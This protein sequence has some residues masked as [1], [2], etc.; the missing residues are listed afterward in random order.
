MKR[1]ALKDQNPGMFITY[2][3][4]HQREY[5]NA[6]AS[7]EVIHTSVG[8]RDT[9]KNIEPNTSVREG[10]SR[11]DY[12]F[13]RPSEAVPQLQKEV[14]GY[15]MEAYR[16][17]GVVRNVIDLMGD[18]GSQ[19]ITI[20]HPSPRIQEFYRKWF[21]KVRGVERSER[22][23]NLLYRCANVI[24]KRKM[25]KV[26]TGNKR[27]SSLSKLK[28][29]VSKIDKLSTEKGNIPIEYV[30]LNPLS[31]EIVGE[32]LSQFIGKN[33]YALK[34]PLLLSNTINYPKTLAEKQLVQQLPEDIRN[35][36]KSATRLL[37]LDQDKIRALF[38]K[39]DDWQLWADPMIR[40]ILDDLLLL[41][42]MKLADLA[43]LDGVI[44]QIRVW[45]LGHINDSHPEASLFPTATAINKL[46]NIL[47]SNTGGGVFD[48]IWGP[49]L[50][51]EDFS[52]TAHQFLGMSKYEPTLNSI[53]EGLGVPPTLTGSSSKGGMTNNSISLK[54]LIQRL[55]YGRGILVD[56]WVQEIELVRQAMGFK[57]PA[58][59]SFDRMILNDEASEKALLIQL[60][61]RN[62]ISVESLQKRMGE[63][64]ELEVLRMKRESERQKNGG[65]APK[66][67]PFQPDKIYELIKASLVKG[68]ITPKEAG[69]ELDES[70][71]KPPFMLQL[72]KSREQPQDKKP[73]GQPQQG[74]PKNAKDKQKRDQRTPKALGE[75][76]D[77][78]AWFLT[79]LTWAK[80][81]QKEL[82][83]IIN[84]AILS[85]VGKQNLRQLTDSETEYVENLKFIVLASCDP[86]SPIKDDLVY[87][88][89]EN[90]IQ[91]PTEFS[92]LYK[93]LRQSTAEK[94]NKQL[95]FDENRHIQAVTYAL[96]KG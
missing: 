45:K 21:D 5:A 79:R 15:C 71:D 47:L 23:L 52:T 10:F 54:T 24:V 20:N 31:L 73:T 30:F 2:N 53:Y 74:R 8:G 3:Q 61:D 7:I 90:N 64:P 48:L 26:S 29:D 4:E 11:S 65:M 67:G 51:F 94:L 17:I 57:Q 60:A 96:L 16:K 93:Q 35:A 36:A 13:F 59:I 80:Q 44:S 12:E 78:T 6:I 72:E 50:T 83:D 75:N 85:V 89:I 27:F 77:D 49:D 38:Y 88:S 62:L 46:H 58:T 19:G 34:L 1:P 9:W 41:E 56:F 63:L 82:A 40:A 22:F 69:L 91:L 33:A 39:K 92:T 76:V 86:F 68:L 37:L 32:S 18:F 66:V 14:I 70:F 42:K 95:S 55:E 25:A 87:K 84:P 81:A 28:P 43:A